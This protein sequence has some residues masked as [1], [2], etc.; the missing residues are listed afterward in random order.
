VKFIKNYDGDTLTVNIPGVHPLLGKKIRIRVNGI[1]TPEIRGR[2][3]CEKKKARLAKKLAYSLLSKAKRI[4]LLNVKRGKYFR[5]VADVF[6][7]QKKNLAQVLLKNK[8][9]YRYNGKR[10]PKVNWCKI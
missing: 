5:I 1:D 7:D 8:L 9:A 10:K 4:D 3:A 6:I 2:S